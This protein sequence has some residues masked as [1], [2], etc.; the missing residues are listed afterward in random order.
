MS[1]TASVQVYPPSASSYINGNLQIQSMFHSLREN[2]LFLMLLQVYV[3]LDSTLISRLL[4][5]YVSFDSKLN[6]RLL[7]FD[8]ASDSIIS[9]LN[10]KCRELRPLLFVLKSSTATSDNINHLFY[11]K[12]FSKLNQGMSH[13]VKTCIDCHLLA[14]NSTLDRN[15]D[16][17]NPFAMQLRIVLLLPN[18]FVHLPSIHSS[19]KSLILIQDGFTFVPALESLLLSNL[20]ALFLVLA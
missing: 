7:R 18:P 17:D 14:H 5:V 12:L 15:F 1:F 8:V 6:A 16:R 10:S 20:D 3:P 9:A 11:R 4:Q 13:I 19:F 2:S